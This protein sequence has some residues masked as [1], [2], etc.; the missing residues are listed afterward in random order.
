MRLG[1]FDRLGT[2]DLA[3]VGKN[4]GEVNRHR[5]GIDGR[6]HLFTRLDFHQLRARLADLM[7]KRIAMTLLDDDF[8]SGKIVYIRNVTHAWF[9]IQ[10]H[11]ACI[12]DDH[13]GGRS[14]RYQTGVPGGGLA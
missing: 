3:F 6:E 1:D 11:H 14:T 9:E 12:A 2:A 8:V 7:V 10:G 13:G 4:I 5:L